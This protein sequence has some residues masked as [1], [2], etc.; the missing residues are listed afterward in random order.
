MRYFHAKLLLLNNRSGADLY[1]MIAEFAGQGGIMKKQCDGN[2]AI[3]TFL[4]NR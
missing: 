1:R 3:T 2:L 4:L